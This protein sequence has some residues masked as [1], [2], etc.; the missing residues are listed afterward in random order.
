MLPGREG[1]LTLLEK[2]QSRK[3]T[4]RTQNLYKVSF[5]FR[6]RKKNQCLLW[7]NQGEAWKVKNRRQKLKLE[8]NQL[9]L[10]FG[11]WCFFLPYRRKGSKRRLR[12]HLEKS[13]GNAMWWT[14]LQNSTKSRA[15]DWAI[16]NATH[17]WY[18]IMEVGKIKISQISCNGKHS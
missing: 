9:H 5:T 7:C 15:M 2:P 3:R 18:P 12:K 4:L 17:W 1:L 14:K 10:F 8:I 6:K 16:Q 11:V 13:R